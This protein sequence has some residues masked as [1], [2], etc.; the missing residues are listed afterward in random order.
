MREKEVVVIVGV[1]LLI[2]GVVLAFLYSGLPFVSDDPKRTETLSP[3]EPDRE[4]P[5]E[6]ILFR[7]DFD[8]DLSRWE[9]HGHPPPGID[10]NRGTPAPS[11]DSRGDDLWDNWAVSRALFTYSDGLII[12]F[13]MFLNDSLPEACWVDGVVRIAGTRGG[14]GAAVQVSH[15]IV[16]N[17][18]YGNPPEERNLSYR[19]Y[20]I[21][22][23]SGRVVWFTEVGGDSDEDLGEWHRY[24]IVIRPDHYADF[25]VDGTLRYHSREPVNQSFQN[26]PLAIGSR[27]HPDYGPALIDSIRVYPYSGS[28]DPAQES[29]YGR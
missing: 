17:A 16:G 3:V 11:F 25:Y 5:R 23:S 12:V 8:G 24:A 28:F 19:D 15:R 26:M 14:A 1:C 20:G 4:G 13:D 18:C 29:E 7:E 21:T 9:L 10:A 6:E 27:S 22:N 2:M